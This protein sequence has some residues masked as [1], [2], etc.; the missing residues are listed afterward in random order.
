[1]SKNQ[2]LI[3]KAIFQAKTRAKKCFH[4]IATLQVENIVHSLLRVRG[5]NSRL[6]EMFDTSPKEGEE[7]AQKKE[8]DTDSNDDVGEQRSV[9]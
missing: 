8:G 5:L 9:P 1:M 6:P 3:S 7:S 2:N 4:W